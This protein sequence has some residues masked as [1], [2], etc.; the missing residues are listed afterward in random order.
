MT[1]LP[2]FLVG[3]ATGVLSGFGVGGGSLLLIY[4]T[5][6]AAFPQHEAQGINLIY[7]L[8]A[9][10]AALPSHF[11][12]D[13]IDKQVALPAIIGGLL[14][15]ALAAVLSNNLDVSLLRKLFGIFLLIIGLLELFRK[16]PK[17][18]AIENPERS[19]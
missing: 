19:K 16:D 3:I 11:K 15:S 18:K 14:F 4:L 13:F 17:P 6:F 8:P 1:Y 9:A 5:A 12:N 2:G 7:F 10:L